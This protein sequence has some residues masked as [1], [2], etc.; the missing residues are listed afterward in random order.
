[1]MTDVPWIYKDQVQ[2]FNNM[3]P[4]AWRPFQEASEL[5]SETDYGLTGWTLYLKPV[6][7]G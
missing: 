4:S 1:M 5:L 3:F 2:Q 7:S 6:N